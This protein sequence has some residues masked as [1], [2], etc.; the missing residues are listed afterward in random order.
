MRSSVVRIT[1]TVGAAAV[2]IAVF[3]TGVASADP[4]AGQTYS[5]AAAKISS[6]NATATIATVSGDQVATDDCI[7]TSSSKS[8]FLDASGDGPDNEILL[9]LNCNATLASPGKPGNSAMSPQGRQA[10]KDQQAAQ[11]INDNPDYCQQSDDILAWCER[12]C[13]RTGMC[14]I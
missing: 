12:I 9:N 5:E 7:V 4:Y 8:M 11:N 3:G 14:E 2:S 13:N 10:K 1:S 6:R